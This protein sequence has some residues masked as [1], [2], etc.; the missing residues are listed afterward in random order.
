M[1]KFSSRSFI[2]LALEFRSLINFDLIFCICCRLGIQ[3]LSFVCGYSVV[4]HHLLRRLF[5]PHWMV[6]SPLQKISWHRYMDLSPDFQL[7]FINLCV[8]ATRGPHSRDYYSFVVSFET[9]K[10]EPS[11]FVLFLDCS[12]Y[13]GSF[14][15]PYK[16]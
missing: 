9:E 2:V 13:S 7:S 1:A 11:N 6:L 5:F 12:G 10:S 4:L 3:V 14:I 8:Y 15:F 16:S